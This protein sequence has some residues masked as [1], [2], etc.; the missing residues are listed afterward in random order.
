MSRKTKPL[1]VKFIGN[2]NVEL[3]ARL[4]L[5]LESGEAGLM[6]VEGTFKIWRD[7]ND[8]RTEETAQPA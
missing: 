1:K 3:A 6:P 7:T 4:P 8:T 5:E 2:L